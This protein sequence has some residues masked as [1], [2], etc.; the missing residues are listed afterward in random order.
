MKTE[1]WRHQW[2]MLSIKIV[3]KLEKHSARLPGLRES[4]SFLPE[5]HFMCS[6]PEANSLWVVLTG[7]ETKRI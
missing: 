2:H 4:C 3:L 5:P 7:S 6:E 1:L